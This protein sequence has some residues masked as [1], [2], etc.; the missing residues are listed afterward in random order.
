ME[1]YTGQTWTVGEPGSDDFHVFGDEKIAKWFQA[2]RSVFPMTYGSKPTDGGYLFMTPEERAE[3]LSKEPRLAKFIR[4]VYG[5]REFI[6][7]IERYC[8]WLVDASPKDIKSSKILYERV[9]KV[10]EFRLASSDKFTR[11]SAETPH[12]FQRIRQPSTNYLLI[13]S[14]SSIKR[15]YI[16]MGYVSPDVI[17][18]NACFALPHATP[19][20]FGMLTSSTHMGWTRRVAGRLKMDYRYSN[21]LAYNTFLW[22]KSNALQVK[23]IEATG[24]KILDVRAK[25]PD[26]SY[27]DLYDELTMPKD[28]REAH[29]EN[30]VAVLEA[31]GLPA[32]LPE[33][34]IVEYLLDKY[35]RFTGQITD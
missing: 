17:I 5:S 10:K 8:F 35:G 28:L 11:K 20:H 2:C 12:L 23:R 16:P 13:P 25:Y 14:H 26:C 15:Q 6:Q 19:Y 29:R 7:N 21:T 4:K 9:S 32:D 22:P 3:I 31:F 34:D 18:T 24:Q 1:W 27:A 30:D 33:D